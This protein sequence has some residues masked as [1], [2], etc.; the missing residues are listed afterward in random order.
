V[1]ART[2]RASPA[3]LFPLLAPPSRP[4][5]PP[6]TGAA[7]AA[8][9]DAKNDLR[10]MIGDSTRR[11]VV[12]M[13]IASIVCVD[14]EFDLHDTASAAVCAAIERR[15]EAPGARIGIAAGNVEH[16]D[17]LGLA[18]RL[19]ELAE[20][21]SILVSD[22]IRRAVVADIG[23]AAGE[24]VD[25]GALS[26]SGYVD[27]VQVFE[28]GLASERTRTVL[29]IE[30]APHARVRAAGEE[31]EERAR[32]DAALRAWE[33]R[34]W[35][36]AVAHRGLLDHVVGHDHLFAFVHPLDAF[37]A[38]LAAVAAMEALHLGTVAIG[39]ERGQMSYL[40][41]RWWS[42]AWTTAQRIRGSE[43][44]R[45][46]STMT[47]VDAIGAPALAALGLV[48]EV[49]EEVVQKGVRDPVR[50]AQLRIA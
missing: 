25:L 21:D 38:A 28:L 16:G 17:P 34:L 24:F 45:I 30:V 47:V 5:H 50:V 7:A 1:N 35:D 36:L 37:Q 14:G 22:T 27:R 29:A 23:Y 44:R 26:T 11:R 12:A 18:T 48:I 15:R 10:S 42:P 20:P 8:P 33:R 9:I 4:S 40:A 39:I 46:A 43:Y 2:S 3:G 49:V 6:I 31:V 41:D 19:Y 13:M 32:Y